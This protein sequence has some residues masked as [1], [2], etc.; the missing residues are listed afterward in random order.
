MPKDLH[1]FLDQ[2][3]QLGPEELATIDRPVRPADFDVTAILE[4]LTRDQRF[5]T[6]LFCCTEDL[7]GQPSRF[8]IVTNLFA[9]RARCARGLGLPPEQDKMELSLAYARLERSQLPAVTIP[10]GEAPAK[11]VVCAGADADLG[12]LPIVR[13]FEMDLGPV[14]TMATI[15]KDPDEGFY[16]VTFIKVFYKDLPR[17]G[18]LTIHSP[19]HLRIAKKYEQRGQPAP[20][21]AMLGHHPAFSLGSLAL[22]PWGTN[23]YDVIGSFLGEPVRLTASETWGADFLVPADAEI[24]IEG[25]IPPGEKEICDP[26]G[27]VTRTYQPQGLKQALDVT[28]MSFRQDA[29]LQDV[30]SGHEEHWY[31]GSIAK[32]GSMFNNL[33]RQH[34]CIKAVH[35]PN[36]ACGRLAAYVSMRKER[37]GI[38]KRVGMSA[39]ME[40]WQFNWAIVVDEDVDVFDE[41][42]VLWAVY[43]NVDPSRD[44]D[45]LK[46]QY[47]I[48]H[49]AAADQKVIIDATRPL[50][51]AFPAKIN[52]PQTALDRIRLADYGL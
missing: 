12:M 35:L 2:L 6:L 25:L 17:R 11:Q 10:V 19:H 43:T 20:V 46:N 21:V 40:S 36:S 18:G 41:Q 14:L 9:T 3:R 30:F 28:A 42:E 47:N 33:E 51:Y 38:A 34:G 27:E 31:L 22:S 5:P 1:A 50:D 48:F 49:S 39:L 44:V 24:L 23:D 29:I 26:F 37:E 7:H 32:E 15:M 16:D 4:L 8:P 52:V 45:V 13:H